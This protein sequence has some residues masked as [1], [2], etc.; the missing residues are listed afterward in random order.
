VLGFTPTLGQVRVAT[1]KLSFEIELIFLHRI[2][3]SQ[4]KK[5]MTPPDIFAA[6]FDGSK[7]LSMPAPRM[8]VN[9]IPNWRSVQ[10]LVQDVLVDRAPNS[11]SLLYA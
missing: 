9:T 2:M 5:S 8:F 1:E 6:F 7:M 3:R 10:T 4:K 11:W